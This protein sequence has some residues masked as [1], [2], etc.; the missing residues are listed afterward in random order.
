MI[1][2]PEKKLRH[3]FYCR[4]F[5]GTLYRQSFAKNNTGHSSSQSRNA[6]AL[7]S[8]LAN[9]EDFAT[10][11]GVSSNEWGGFVNMPA[12]VNGEGYAPSSNVLKQTILVDTEHEVLG[13][14]L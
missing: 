3:L 9:R 4:T 12:D 10:R 6:L 5:L 2:V 8:D 7:P 14:S 11:P 1:N 13:L